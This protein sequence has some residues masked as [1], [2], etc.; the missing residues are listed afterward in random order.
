[1]A[2]T[3]GKR[4]AALFAGAEPKLGRAILSYLRL[5]SPPQ[6]SMR[7]S[8]AVRVVEELLELIAHG[9]VS[10]GSDHRRATSA[11]WIA[12]IEQMLDSTTALRLPLS[13]H[14]YLV[15]VAHGIAKEQSVKRPPVRAT[16]TSTPTQPDDDKQE[17]IGRILADLR[18]GLLTKEAAQAQRKAILEGE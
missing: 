9:E 16:G 17:R 5:F 3:D 6:R 18:L 15:T 2:D 8:K 7:M 11:T 1:M 13:S 10:K 12:A 14:A 4:L